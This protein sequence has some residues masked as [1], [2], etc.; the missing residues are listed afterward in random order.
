MVA[1]PEASG[2][3]PQKRKKPKSKKTPTKTKVT[4]PPEPTEDSKQSHSVSSGHVPD[5]QDPK[6]SIQLVGTRLLALN[7]IR[8]LANHS[9]CLRVKNLIPKTQWET[10]N[11]LIQDCLPRVFDKGMVKTMSLPEGPR[12]DKDL[13]GLKPPTDIEPLT[14]LVVDP[15]GTHAKY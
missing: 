5:P 6:R 2:S 10:N 4:P 13:E 14:N 7:L 12:G 15:S 3:L 9:F 1:G 8:A 11:P